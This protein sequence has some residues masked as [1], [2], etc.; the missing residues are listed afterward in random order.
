MLTF[1]DCLRECIGNLE[2][3]RGFDRLCGTDLA[4]AR[5]RGVL[6]A[7]V[8]EATGFGEER[9]REDVGRFVAFVHETVWRR[10]PPGARA[11][12]VVEMLEG[13]S[14]HDLMGGDER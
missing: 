5:R 6:T 1:E 3:V 8:D 14:I 11:P 10:L 13:M 4:G 12:E 9:R 7:M 2:F